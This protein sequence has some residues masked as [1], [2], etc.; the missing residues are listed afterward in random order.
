[1]MAINLN[2]LV[3]MLQPTSW[4]WRSGHGSFN[5]QNQMVKQN[6]LTGLGLVMVNHVGRGWLWLVMV[7]SGWFIS[8]VKGSNKVDFFF[9]FR[10]RAAWDIESHQ[11]RH[12]R[13]VVA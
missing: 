11:R 2:G 4:V 8:D 1:M 6:Q 9:F 7:G 13:R 5:Q 12:G 3:N 10:E